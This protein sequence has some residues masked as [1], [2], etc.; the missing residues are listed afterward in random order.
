MVARGSGR[1]GAREA[2]ASA[3]FPGPLLPACSQVH[4][5]LPAPRLVFLSTQTRLCA[6]PNLWGSPFPTDKVLTHQLDPREG[7]YFNT[8]ALEPGL[9]GSNSDLTT[10]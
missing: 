5:K 3:L 4:P 9:L 2:S 6:A 10:P 7:L 8:E 1:A